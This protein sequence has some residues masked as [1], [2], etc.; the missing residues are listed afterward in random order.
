MRT[1]VRYVACADPPGALGT[2]SSGRGRS[3]LTRGVARRWDGVPG[4]LGRLAGRVGPWTGSLG[5]RAPPGLETAHGAPGA[6]R[7]ES[8][9]IHT[10][11]PRRGAPGR[12]RASV[13]GRQP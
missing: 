6:R 2:Y 1:Q 5:V 11:G 4:R 7:V 3:D 13:A 8:E 10:P 12:H 9:R